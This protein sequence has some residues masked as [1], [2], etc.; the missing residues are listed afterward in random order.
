MYAIRSYYAHLERK[1]MGWDFM[2][3]SA[4]ASGDI[5][6]DGYLDLI[7]AKPTR[8]LS[9]WINNQDGNFSDVTRIT[10]YNVCYTKLL[11]KAA[12]N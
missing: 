11:R 8:E 12:A 4:L 7:I 3:H 5:N 9:V 10:S 1:H 6:H 2:H